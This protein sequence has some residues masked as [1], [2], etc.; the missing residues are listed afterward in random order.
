MGSNIPDM[1]LFTVEIMPRYLVASGALNKYKEYPETNA[2]N[3]DNTCGV[4]FC[5]YRLN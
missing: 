3:F 1:K 2:A 5:Y 4:L